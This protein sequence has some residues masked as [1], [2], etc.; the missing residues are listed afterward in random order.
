MSAQTPPGWYP[1]PTT[2]TRVRWFD[3]TAWTPHTAPAGIPSPLPPVKQGWSGAKIAA[4]VSLSVLG[5]VVVLG[6]L[7]AVAIPVFLD[8][9]RKEAFAAAVQDATCEQVA[10]EAVELSHQDLQEGYVGLAS[11]AGAQVTKDERS[12]ATRP[13]SGELTY[14][15]TCQ[16]IGTWDDG[17]TDV[18]RLSLSLDSAGTHVIENVTT[19]T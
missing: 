12:T 14:L 7:G 2:P 1:D 10:L 11:V 16:G 17:S 9:E 15:M 6:I 4:V 19:T 13:A 3:G 18:I 5:L 8:Q